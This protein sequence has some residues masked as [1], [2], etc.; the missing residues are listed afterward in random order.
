M[1]LR[2]STSLARTRANLRSS[3][4]MAE[5]V[6]TTSVRQVPMA[7]TAQMAARLSRAGP[8]SQSTST[9]TTA[10]YSV[11]AAVAAAVHTM[12]PERAAILVAEAAAVR[13]FQLLQE[14]M[15]DQASEHPLL[16]MVLTVES[17]VRA[18]AETAA[19][20]RLQMADKAECGD[21]A[22]R[23]DSRVMSSP[24]QLRA[25]STIS[26]GLVVLQEWHSQDLGQSL[27][28]VQIMKPPSGQ[29]TA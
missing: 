23:R 28:Q 22:A 6:A 13:A 27:S 10:T 4:G 18:L 5:M 19:D 21:L 12:T 25:I 9:S 8:H 17:E 20:L 15:A 16:P 7:L 11:A 14:V 3:E 29:L 2:R 26:A 24:Q 1:V